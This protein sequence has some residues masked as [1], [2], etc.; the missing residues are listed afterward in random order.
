MAGQYLLGE[1]AIQQI[2]QLIQSEL[3]R[4]QQTPNQR[5]FSVPRLSVAEGLLAEDL[6]AGSLTSVVTAS[7]SVYILDVVQDDR[8]YDADLVDAS[9]TITLTNRDSSLTGTS[10]D[11]CIAL[12]WSREWRPIWVGCS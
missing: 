6:S 5:R 7:M 4:V 12:K 10:G 8:V 3:R 1:K 2:R 11:Y 9:R